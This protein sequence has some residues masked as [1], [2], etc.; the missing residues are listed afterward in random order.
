MSDQ[1]KTIGHVYYIQ[2]VLLLSTGNVELRHQKLGQIIYG[3]KGF[4][5]HDLLKIFDIL[6]VF[7]PVSKNIYINERECDIF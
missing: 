3:S 2:Y 7:L 4:I 5:G 6:R 1:S